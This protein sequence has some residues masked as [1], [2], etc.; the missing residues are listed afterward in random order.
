ML[1]GSDVTY[2]IRELIGALKRLAVVG[3]VYLPPALR[4]L[5]V[6][7]QP[8]FSPYAG[9]CSDIDITLS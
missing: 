8:G 5:R 7:F 1:A 3:W 9:N 4:Y 2:L 6:R